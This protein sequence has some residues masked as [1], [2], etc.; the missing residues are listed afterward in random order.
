VADEKTPRCKRFTQGNF[1]NINQLLEHLQTCSRCRN[2]SENIITG[3]ELTGHEE[4]QIDVLT[5]LE[6]TAPADREKVYVSDA[7][8]HCP[9]PYRKPTKT[10]VVESARFRGKTLEIHFATVADKQP[11][12]HGQDA[13]IL[14]LLM[15][16]SHRLKTRAIALE[17]VREV[18]K[19]LGIVWGKG[20][21]DYKRFRNRIRRLAALHLRIIIAGEVVLNYRVVDA[22]NLQMPTRQD[23]E[24]EANGQQRLLPFV[25]TFSPEFYAH[26]IKNYVAIPR[27]LLNAFK[28]SPVE[29]SLAKFLYR[30]I[31]HARQQSFIPLQDLQ[32]ERGSYD[33]NQRRFRNKLRRFIKKLELAWPEIEGVLLLDGDKIRILTTGGLKMI[34]DKTK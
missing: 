6:A 8:I 4:F 14:D 27:Q 17:S 25:F 16:E 12:A 19:F 26:F 32:R 22:E 30:R 15:S 2:I 9:L 3:D 5:E 29:Y 28:G 20:G 33:S 7:L 11:V 31:I 1:L 18:M 13:Y 24:D 23:V 21:K 10:I 34:P